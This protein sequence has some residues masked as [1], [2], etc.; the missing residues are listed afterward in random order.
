MLHIY[1]WGDGKAPNES[2]YQDL[3]VVLDLMN[4]YKKQFKGPICFYYHSLKI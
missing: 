2:N 1:E 4:E 3:M